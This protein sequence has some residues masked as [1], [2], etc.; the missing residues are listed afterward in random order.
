MRAQ[1]IN[2]LALLE[3]R[4]DELLEALNRV[5]W[6]FSL[7]WNFFECLCWYL[8]IEMHELILFQ[9]ML[10]VNTWCKWLSQNIKIIPEKFNS[11]QTDVKELVSNK[12]YIIYCPKSTKN[13]SE[14]KLI[15]PLN[16]SLR[17]YFIHF[18]FDDHY[19]RYAIQTHCMYVLLCTIM[20]L[21]QHSS[22]HYSSFLSIVLLRDIMSYC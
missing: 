16:F 7:D 2:S 19:K 6:A 20:Y 9:L 11:L 13:L 22:L 15:S 14:I 17:K 8:S 1:Y 18:L 12:E 4:V 21:H 3:K 10:F 5:C